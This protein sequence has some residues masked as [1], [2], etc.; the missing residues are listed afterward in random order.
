VRRQQPLHHHL[1]AGLHQERYVLHVRRR[2]R[3]PPLTLRVLTLALLLLE[4]AGLGACRGCAESS[5]AAH[6]DALIPTTPPVLLVS[7]PGSAFQ[8][9]PSR[10]GAWIFVSLSEPDGGRPGVLVFLRGA[11]APVL[12]RRLDLDD[13]PAGMVVTHDGKLLVVTAGDHVYFIDVDRLVHGHAAPLV[14]TVEEEGR[15]NLVR[16][17][18]NVSADDRLLFVSDERARTIT[19]YDL[20]RARR[21]GHSAA[22]ILGQVPVGNA[23]IDLAFSPDGKWLYTTSQWMPDW[24]SMC[25]AEESLASAP[26]H[27][28]GAIIVVDVARA[29]SDPAGSVVATVPAGCNPVRLVLSPRGDVAYV[30][31]RGQDAVLAFDTH[32]LLADPGHARLATIPVGS[33]PV[34]LTVIDGGRRVIVTSSNRYAGAGADHQPL[35]VIDTTRL[36]QG[37]GA[38]VGTVPAGAFPR[39]LRTTPDG[40]TLL[41]TNYASRT[42]QI[43][44]LSRLSIAPA[45]SGTPAAP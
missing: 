18:A 33:S 9:L 20:Q 26:D 43:L 34:G 23:P 38:V 24:P 32:K 10:D 5:T 17:Y 42:L 2:S 37:A 3:A 4:T 35:H 19:V 41:L 8:A 45:S 25:G 15:R 13:A 40:R 28:E 7:L 14:G 30:S 44:D 22:A 31:A 11:G 27:P 12:V 6:Q 29:S 39:E 1:R 21:D 36:E 16:I